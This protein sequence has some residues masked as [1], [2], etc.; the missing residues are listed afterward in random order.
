MLIGQLST[1]KDRGTFAQILAH[2]DIK[3]STKKTVYYKDERGRLL[4]DQE[5]HY[6]WLPVK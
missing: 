6:E 5:V 1:Q 2:V 4:I 3:D